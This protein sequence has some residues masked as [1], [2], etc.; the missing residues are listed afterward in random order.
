MA[1]DIHNP[2]LIGAKSMQVAVV[3][4]GGAES[5]EWGA[6]SGHR[7]YCSIGLLLKAARAVPYDS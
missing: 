6:E 7:P 3:G 2:T 4:K 1:D 5:G